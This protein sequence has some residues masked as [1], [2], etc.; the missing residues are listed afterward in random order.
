MGLIWV[1]WT[2]RRI[3]EPSTAESPP[4]AEA[5]ADPGR[6]AGRSKRLV[7]STSVA[8]ATPA[9]LGETV[10]IGRLEVTPLDV[11]TGPFSLERTVGRPERRT[12]GKGALRL[13]IR[14]KNVSNDL[15]LAPLD[16]A[17]VRERE[18]GQP[19]SYIET[20]PGRPLIEMYPLA[21]ESEWSIVGQEFRELKPGEAFETLVVSTTDAAASLAAEMTWRLRLRTDVNQSDDLDIHFRA[22]EVQREP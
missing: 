19:D 14:L 17:F 18:P 20:T 16:E 6:Q 22:N 2:G 7:P 8:D 10:R 3:A 9:Q 12:G 1:L 11:T 5:V 15:I 21:V 13:R 4:T